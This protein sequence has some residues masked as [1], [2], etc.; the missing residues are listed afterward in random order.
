METPTP[1]STKVGVSMNNEPIIKDS[2]I[3]DSTQISNELNILSKQ[4]DEMPA[5]ENEPTLS[6]LLASAEINLTKPIPKPPIC[7]YIDDAPLF[8]LGDISTIIG[9]A[10]SRKTF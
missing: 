4:F 3:I 7:L 2:N 1:A 6:E 9:K 5:V 8:Y 10:K